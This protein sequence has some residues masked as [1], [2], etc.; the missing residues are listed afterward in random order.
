M[1]GVERLDQETQSLDSTFKFIF[2][3]ASGAIPHVGSSYTILVV[4]MPKI[5]AFLVYGGW[6][7]FFGAFGVIMKPS[8]KLLVSLLTP[9]ISAH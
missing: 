4:D 6:K 5:C 9:T 1:G 3:P 7:F 2:V 8:K